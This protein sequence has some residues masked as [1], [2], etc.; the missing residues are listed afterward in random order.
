MVN[1]LNRNEGLR[2]RAMLDLYVVPAARS[3]GIGRAL[4][5]LAG[6]R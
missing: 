6:S 2:G 4:R 5:A 1:A 3:R